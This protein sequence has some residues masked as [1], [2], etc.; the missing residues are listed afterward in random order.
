MPDSYE[1]IHVLSNMVHFSRVN[2]ESIQVLGSIPTRM[3]EGDRIEYVPINPEYYRVTD[4]II[5]DIEI[6]LF[7]S[8]LKTIKLDK[9]ELQLILHFK[10]YL[11]L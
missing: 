1:I 9:G 11:S 3:I 8:D 4:K 6:R 10:K 2:S 7:T 5:N